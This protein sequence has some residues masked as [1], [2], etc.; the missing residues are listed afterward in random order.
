[1]FYVRHVEGGITGTWLLCGLWPESV[2]IGGLLYWQCFNTPLQ[3][4][5]GVNSWPH[6]PGSDKCISVS[7][8]S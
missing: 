1:M 3:G 7:W 5:E 8:R 6:F 2:V 4:P